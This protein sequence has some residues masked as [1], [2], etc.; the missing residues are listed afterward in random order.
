MCDKQP[1]VA[2]PVAA[3]PRN[4]VLSNILPCN[5]A[6]QASKAACGSRRKR[7][8]ELPSHTHCPVIGVCLSMPVLRRLVGKAL[9]SHIDASDYEFHAAAV[10]ECSSR[11][12]ISEILQRELDRRYT[13]VIKRF[14]QSKTTEGLQFLWQE[15]LK[16]ADV[17]G[18]LWATLSHSRCD[19]RLREQVCHDIHMFQHQVGAC[20]R[21]DLQRLE[22]LQEE[23]TS[24]IDEM[25]ATKERYVRILQDRT[26]EIESLNGKLMRLRAQ[27][28]A[29]ES[30]FSTLQ[31]E[32]E[33]VKTAS[34]SL[35]QRIE[36]A[37]KMDEQQKRF[38]M[39]MQE[40]NHWQRR[41]EQ[42]TSR[43]DI[44]QKQVGAHVPKKVC[45]E[46]K[47]EPPVEQ[48]NMLCDK[49]VLCVGGRAASVPVYRR[50]IERTGG[51]FLHHDGGEEHS[52]AQLDANLAAADLVI[53]QAGCISHHAYWRV[54]DYCKRT[55]KQCMFVE[56]PS[57]SSFAKCLH[58]FTTT[59]TEPGT[60]V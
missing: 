21:A 6:L 47:I 48:P 14:S 29:R 5:E 31:E 8:W 51:K 57:E 36:L 11:R 54:K 24:L 20:N 28:I 34:Q 38:H 37:K 19:E 9:G 60:V 41:A 53:C 30:A 27:L 46:E 58:Q 45:V 16:R 26:D 35:P 33:N 13:G 12:P 25:A 17:A 55:G 42:E 56:K 23:N 40:R 50:L 44:L 7:L 39:V 18:A 4:T 15:A 1:T 2:Y 3:Y 10:T 32:L 22:Q 59:A 52:N 43:A 49:S